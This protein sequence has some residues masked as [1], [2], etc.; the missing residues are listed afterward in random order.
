MSTIAW[1]ALG[2]LTGAVAALVLGRRG[3]G[4]VLELVLGAAGAVFAG[5]VFV[6]FGA[7][8]VA[9]VNLYSGLV[10]LTGAVLALFVYHAMA[11]TEKI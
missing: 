4:L 1:I 11:A 3:L 8:G 9:G 5:V 7:A 10:S 6:R 2:L